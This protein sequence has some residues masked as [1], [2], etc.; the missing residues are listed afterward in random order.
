MCLS[1]EE[2]KEEEEKEI[3]YHRECVERQY[4]KIIDEYFKKKDEE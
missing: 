4:V 3:D 1:D 2:E